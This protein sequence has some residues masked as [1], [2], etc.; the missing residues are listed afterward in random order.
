MNNEQLDTLINEYTK[1]KKVEIP[2][3]ISDRFES[4]VI[5]KN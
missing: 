3:T 1:E 5:Q 4:K 2:K